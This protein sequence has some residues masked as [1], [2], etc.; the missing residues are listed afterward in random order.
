MAQKLKRLTVLLGVLSLIIICI[1]LPYLLTNTPF[2]Y[3]GD[4]K[5]QWFPYFT[6]F[7]NL[8]NFNN[9]LHGVFPFYSWD[10]F[11]GTN[12]WASK[13]AHY[14]GDLFGY[15]SLLSPFHFY[16][17]YEWMTGL[18]ILVSGVTFYF[19]ISEFSNQFKSKLIAC[20]SFSFSSWLIY[21]YGQGSFLSFYAIVP[22][23][24]LGIEIFIQ[25]KKKSLFLISTIILLFTN[26]YFFFTLSVFSPIYYIYRYY[27]VKV[28][29]KDFVK[30][31]GVIILVYLSGVMATFVLTLPTFYYMMQNDRV[32]SFPK[33]FQ[34]E[35]AQ[36]YTH[37]LAGTFVPSQLFIYGNNVFETGYHISREITLWAGSITALLLPQIFTDE[38]RKFRNSSLFLYFVIV[39]IIISPVGNSIMHGLSEFSFRWTFLI[40]FMNIVISNRYLSSIEKINRRTLLISLIV[41]LFIVNLSIPI[42]LLINNQLGIWISDYWPQTRLFIFISFVFMIFTAVLTSKSKHKYVFLLILTFIEFATYSTYLLGF[43][44]REPLSTWDDI[45]NV[46]HVLQDSQNELN[47]YL[48]TLDKGN[49]SLYYRIYVPHESLYW[50]YSHNQSVFYQ[51]KG[52]MTYDSTYAPSLNALKRIAPQSME[53]DSGWIFNI[54]DENLIDFLNTKYA[55]VT[56]ENELPQGSYQLVTDSFRGSLMIYRNLNYRP[57]GTSYNSVISYDDF[58]T[59]YSNDLT[60]LKNVVVS[61][62]EDTAK[63]KQLITSDNNSILTNIS[64]YNNELHG[65]ISTLDKTFMVLTI[66]FDPGWK[67]LING[68]EIEKYDV[69][70]GFIGIPI[71][72]GENVLDMYFSPQGFKTGAIVTIIGA[73][74][75]IM[76][77]I[78]EFKQFKRRT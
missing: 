47:A 71:P 35:L 62:S 64:Y 25:E 17:T 63:I 38:D 29:F 34:F 32:G 20:I 55:I 53:F 74:T 26:Y 45:D 40:I 19:F 48:D 67:I 68:I 33:T 59:L 3:G 78:Y 72:A 69:N 43:L 65:R 56:N 23:Y 6:D 66:P 37:I 30:D 21:F 52:L 70:G 27:L 57:L 14:V 77:L 49:S 11:L 15:L 9:I 16:T 46:T 50:N 24:F 12:F 4:L 13:S 1:Y 31:T 2:E 61:K 18:K 42:T 36:I 44:R 10:L 22:L 76:I 8:V 51:V 54:K 7:K 73:L 58:N 28:N 60:L 5:P 75:S 41:I 39:L